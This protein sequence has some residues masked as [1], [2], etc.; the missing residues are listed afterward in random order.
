MWSRRTRLLNN[1]FAYTGTDGNTHVTI[2]EN[3]HIISENQY[4]ATMVYLIRQNGNIE[5]HHD[6][7]TLGLF[8]HGEWLSVLEENGLKTSMIDLNDLYDPFLLE[9]GEYKLKLFLCTN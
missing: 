5:V 1:N 8:S 4:E 2:F 9:D 7:H 6:I 3:N